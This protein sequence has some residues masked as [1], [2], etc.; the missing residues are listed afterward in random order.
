MHALVTD[1]NPVPQ[2]L[3]PPQGQQDLGVCVSLYFTRYQIYTSELLVCTQ[4]CIYLQN[5]RR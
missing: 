1:G 4:T 3:E 5:L 2:A